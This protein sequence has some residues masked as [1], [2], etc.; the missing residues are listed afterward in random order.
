MTSLL[1]SP[2]S[3]R[4]LRRTS[5]VSILTGLFALLTCELPLLFAFV[6]LGSMSSAVAFLRPPPWLE[7][8]AVTAIIL[9]AFTL[10]FLLVRQ[11]W[12]SHGNLNS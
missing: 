12:K 8:L 4:G 6:G 1:T 11:R 9:G 5:K 10:V 3:E 7:L 2:N